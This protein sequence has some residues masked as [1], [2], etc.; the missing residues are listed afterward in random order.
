M[1][2]SDTVTLACG[3]VIAASADGA[4]LTPACQAH[5]ADPQALALAASQDP[6][7][8]A[9]IGQAAAPGAGPAGFSYSGAPNTSPRDRVRFT[10]ADTVAA[11]AKFTDGEIDAVLE[12]AGDD[13][14]SASLILLD[15]LV[16]RYSGACDESVGSVSM[17]YSQRADSY[18]RLG[19]TLRARLAKR[20]VPYGG[21]M[22]RMDKYQ[23]ARNPLRVQPAFTRNMFQGPRILGDTMYVGG[24]D[25][26]A[27]W[28]LG[29]VLYRDV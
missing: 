6:V 1:A 4:R 16:A 22:D 26:Y 28:S 9:L 3:C 18:R 25:Y 7:V 27:R 8:Q 11:S 29:P 14:L 20:G 12:E 13:W 10:L 17:A 2:S 19:D 24:G 5:T 21:G 23:A 15:A